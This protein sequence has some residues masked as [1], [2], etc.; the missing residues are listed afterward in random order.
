MSDGN[1]PSE[2]L[3]V[4]ENWR[5]AFKNLDGELM[6][7][8]FDAIE[9]F[10]YQAEENEHV[11]KTKAEL[12]AYWNNVGNVLDAVP[13]WDEMQRAVAVTGSVAVIYAQTMTSLKIKGVPKPFDGVLRSTHV[14]HQ[15]NG[16]WKIVHYHESRALDLAAILAG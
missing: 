6:K 4:Y 5:R 10:T 11:L 2:V 8:Q 14:L 1:V 15:K 16:Q 12:D 7:A 9:G 3:A 13:Q